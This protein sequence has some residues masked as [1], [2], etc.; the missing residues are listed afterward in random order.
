MIGDLDFTDRTVLVVGGSS[1][2]GNASAQAFRARG[3]AVHVWGTRKTAADYAGEPGSDLDGLSYE[4][5]DVADMDA[6]RHA[7]PKLDRLDVL[8][9]SQGIVLY[10]RKEFG[11]DGFRKVVD[12]NLNSL[13]TCCDKFIEPLKAARG[14]VVI[15][16]STAAYQAT[17]GNPA[18][19]ASKAGALGLTRTLGQ[20]WAGSG[21]RV[22]GDNPKRLRA[23]EE[24]IPAGR[25]GEPGEIAG[26]VLFLA[27]PLAS[28][29]TGQTLPVDGGLILGL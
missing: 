2:I 1:G 16:N 5:V 4:Q 8:V 9:L 18:Y 15:I 6:I 24:R 23:M 26:A 29:V 27:S 7:G 12:V 17:R 19:N 20:A 22:N 3:A 13:M 25:L 28:Y 11:D 14:C 21:V 10:D